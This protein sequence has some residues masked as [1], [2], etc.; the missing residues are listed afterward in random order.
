MLRVL[1]RH[2]GE[3]AA[4]RPL[5]REAVAALL[6]GRDCLLVMATGGGK[7]LAFQL[8]SLVRH[9]AR[10]V[11][12]AQQPQ[13]PQQQQQQ[14]NQKNPPP[15]PPDPGCFSVVVSPLLAL[16]KEQVARLTDELGVEAEALLGETLEERKRAILRDLACGDPSTRLLYTTPE[17]LRHERVAA[18]LGEANDNGSLVCFAVDEAHCAL[19]WGRDFRPAYLELKNRLREAFPSVPIL[20]ATATATENDKRAIVGAL[21]LRL[22]GAG[23]GGG[24]VLVSSA[25]RPNLRY[26]VRY[27]ELLLV[28]SSAANGGS[29]CYYPPSSSDD[30]DEGDESDE[31]DG[32]DSDDGAS[33]DADDDDSKQKTH[34]QQQ[35]QQ[36]DLDRRMSSA[37]TRDLVRWVTRRANKKKQAGIVYARTR[38]RVDSLAAALVG[39]GVDAA[40]FHAGREPDARARVSAQWS[41]GELMVVVATIAFGMGVDRGDVRW[42]AHADPPSSVEGYA[43]EAGRAGRDGEPAESVVW[44]SRADFE[45]VAALQRRGGSGVAVAAVSELLGS[46]GCLRRRLLAHFGERRGG[47]CVEGE[48]ACDFCA[49][50]EGGGAAG[51]GASRSVVRGAAARRALARWQEL[52]RERA[53]R[54]A[55]TFGVK[56][57]GEEEEEEGGGNG[58]GGSESDE[59]GGDG[60][61]NGGAK[62]GKAPLPSW[63]P[64]ATYGGLKKRRR[65]PLATATAAAAPGRPSTALE[66]RSQLP[67]P[68]RA[69]APPHQPVNHVRDLKK[70]RTF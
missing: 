70:T 66:E 68:L 33:S 65:P 57:K 15:P 38:E 34:K 62:K 32:G 29:N 14:Q 8:P 26:R 39:A 55:G 37:A 36:A 16:A 3:R 41:A 30:D 53:A 48:R 1:Q 47:G 20:A 9:E 59:A 46:A 42:V 25:N 17:Q 54:A 6:S 60:K 58:N 49:A 19:N 7:S 31:S 23:E 43:Q 10:L 67:P 24:V 18:A 21:G 22:G 2:W 13:N 69:P 12:A 51:G 5:Q 56:E 28:P 45:T 27:K 11:A 40:P 35:Q 61:E 44:A 52:G 63:G 64:A 4:F 50:G